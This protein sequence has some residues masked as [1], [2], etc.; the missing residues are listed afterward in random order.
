MPTENQTW[1]HAAS[2][3]LRIPLELAWYFP[4][5]KRDIL[6]FYLFF[7]MKVLLIE[8][9]IK[10][11]QSLKKGLMENQIA[12]D[13]AYDGHQGRLLAERGVYDVIIT[14][15]IMPKL[16]GLELVRQLRES[17][18]NTPVIL[19]TALGTT[20][21]KVDGLEAGGD[22]YLVKPV[23]FKELL[24]RIKVLTRR[25]KG[26]IFQN[27]MLSFASIEMNLDT[28]IF[29]RAGKKIDLTPKEFALMEYFIR[30]QGRVIS[31]TELAEKVWEINFE[32]NTNVIEVY[33]N[34]LRN[35]MDKPF[36]YKLIHT[37]FGVGYILE[38]K[39]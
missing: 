36:G 39:K 24:A 19:L 7:L 25:S 17:G 10:A 33:I 30:N 16:N 12:V 32:T 5:K 26:S 1:C 28:K 15:V 38:E 2:N 21:N 20:D 31:K 18:V 6:F 37:V 3:F 27:A 35:K 23:E 13:F 29:T 4:R 8:D 14:D 22:D 9:E 34:Y 11:V